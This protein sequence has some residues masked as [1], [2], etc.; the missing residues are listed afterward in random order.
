MR[1]FSQIYNRVMVIDYC[2]N[3]ICAQYLKNEEME[4]NQIC[5]CIDYNQIKVW[6]G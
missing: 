1:H 2:Q 5:L 3:F 4:F 6:D